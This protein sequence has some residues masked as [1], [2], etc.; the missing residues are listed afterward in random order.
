MS[1]ANAGKQRKK[2]IILIT[3]LFIFITPYIWILVNSFKPN[4]AF[5]SGNPFTFFKPTLDNFSTV[6]ID[7]SF[8]DFFFNS[9]FVATLSTLIS[10]TIGIPSAYGFFRFKI[11]GKTIIMAFLFA[12]VLVPPITLAIPSYFLF[13]DLRLLDTVFALAIA[14]SAFNIVFVI[15]LMTGFFKEIPG[16]LEDSAKID[17]CSTFGVFYHIYFKMSMPCI[18]TVTAFSFIF[19]WN[20]F[21]FPL[22]LSGRHSRT[23]TVAIPVLLQRS[24]TLWGAVCAEAIIHTLLIITLTIVI[25]K[26]IVSGLT[27]GAV[28][29]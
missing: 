2:Y 27:L 17:G 21:L 9:F 6:W 15:W 23:M 29:G 28:K 11:P 3:I 25:F 10:L 8:K 1:T 24:G 20:D 14:D 22:I 12:T 18:V 4:N 19:A 7:K 5:L 16:E 13:R 26:R